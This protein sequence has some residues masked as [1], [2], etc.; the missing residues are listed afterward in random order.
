MSDNIREEHKLEVTVY[1]TK[2][3][4]K[5]N[6]NDEQ[7]ETDSKEAGDRTIHYHDFHNN[8]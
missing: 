4:D 7:N 6:Y 8:K 5:K 1:K 3:F 2:H